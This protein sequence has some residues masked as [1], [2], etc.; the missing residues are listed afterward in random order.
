[1]S[2]PLEPATTASSSGSSVAHRRWHRRSRSVPSRRQRRL[3]MESL[4]DRRLLAGDLYISEFMASNSDSLDD[5][6]G[7]SS[8][9]IEVFN[10]GSTTVDLDGYFLTDD[11]SDLTK[12]EFPSYSL[13]AGQSLVVF[14][15]SRDVTLPSGEMHTN[16]K[17]ASGGE[18]LGLVG[19]DGSTVLHDFGASYPVQFEDVSYGIGMELTSST[20]TLVS[21]GDLISAWEP[22]SDVLGLSWTEASFDDS[23]WP[24]SGPSPVG[25][26]SSPGDYASIIQTPLSNNA[27]SL[28]VRYEF[29][30][31]SLHDVAALDLG[32]RFD[33]GYVAYVNGTRIASQNAPD[34]ISWNSIAAALHPDD[35]A[36]HLETVGANQ[37]VRSLR[38]GQNVL[39]IHG[40]NVSTTSSD[41]LFDAQL[42]GKSAT[43]TQ[44]EE[45]GFRQ[46]PTP[47]WVN[48]SR[49]AGYNDSVSFS[50][51]HGFYTSS[52]TLALST[53][54]A[55]DFIVYT[56]DGSEP[57]V[58]SNFNITNGQLYTNPLTIHQSG[59]VRAAAFENGFRSVPSITQ[60]YIFLDDVL[61]QS[62]TGQS[63]AGWPNSSVN[64]QLLDYGMDPDI[65]SQYGSQA[66]KD[67]LTEISSFSISTDV[68]HLFDSQTGIYVNAQNGGRSWERPASVELLENDG[69]SGFQVNA[70][71]RIRGG[72]SRSGDNPKHAFRFYFRDEYGPTKLN[73]PLF[74]DEGTDQFD[75]LD[76]R[77]AQNYSWSFNGDPQNTFVREV[78]SRDLQR[79]LGH[80]STL[81][82]YHH[83]YINGVYWGLFQTQERVND[84]Y[85]ETYF[86]GD[87]DDYDVVKAGLRT[88]GGPTEI[89][90]GNDQAWL[91]LFQLGQDLADNPTV[92]AN[93]FFTM[94]GLRP[95]GTRDTSLPV[96]VDMENLIDYNLI[97]F[98]TGNL[99]SGLSAFIGNEVGNNWFGLRNRLNQDQGFVFFAHDAE[100]SLGVGNTEFVDRTGPFNEGFQDF[101]AYSNPQFLHQDLLASP[102]YR[103]AFADRV[104]KHMF[105]N[106]AMTPDQ[107]AD[108][109]NERIDVVEDV[110]IAE[111]ARWGD[112][113]R[114]V[115]LNK[116]D[117]RLEVNTI[118][119]Y[120]NS[121]GQTVLGQLAGDGLY[122]SLD[123]PV[124]NQHGGSVP[125][126]F[127]A[128]L[129]ATTG[130]IFY[131]TDGSDP[132]V[133]GGAVSSSASVFNGTPITITSDTVVKARTF[134][135]GVWSALTEAQFTLVADPAASSN[136]RV[137]EMNFNPGDPT[138]AELAVNAVLDN[139][140]FE[141]VEFQNVGNTPIDVGGVVINYGTPFTLPAATL[142]PGAIGLVVSNLSA[143]ELR[144]GS[145][146]HIL[147]E[148]AA[149]RLSNS[150][151]TV[152]ITAS[153][154]SSIQSFTYD[155][156]NDWP[157]FADGHGETMRVI[158]AFGDNSDPL[159]WLPSRHAGGTP[160]E[161]EPVIASASPLRV[162]EVMYHPAIGTGSEFVELY[163]SGSTTLLLQGYEFVEGIE[164]DFD[165]SFQPVLDPGER[166]VIVADIAEF[167][168][169]YGNQVP[170]IG[171]FASGSLSNGGERLILVDNDRHLLHDFAYDDEGLWPTSPDG[172]GF[173]LEIIDI[174]GDYSSPTNWQPST[175]IGGT[176]GTG[177]ALSGDFNGDMMWNCSDINQLTTE[178]A[179]GT[180]SPQFDLTGDGLVTRAD[181]T[182][183]L[184]T[185]GA[186]NPAATGGFPFLEAD[187][188]LDGVVDVGDYVIWNGSRFSVTSNWCDGNFDGNNVVDV[189]DLSIWNVNKFAS[190]S[191]M[192]LASRD[193]RVPAV[194]QTD[195]LSRENI[196][197]VQSDWTADQSFTVETSVSHSPAT[198]PIDV[199]TPPIDVAAPPIRHRTVTRVTG[200][201][202]RLKPESMPLIDSIFAN[203]WGE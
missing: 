143:F 144:Y 64:D 75:V 4:E 140:D 127:A 91:D 182:A 104:H 148:N 170:V 39:A 145:Q 17:L 108:R 65:I 40:M 159:N 199:A 60:S 161:A 8:D 138:A 28:Y 194:P 136:F 32:V 107:N 59:V 84:A 168:S 117:W 15:S 100:H 134:N 24:V 124:L 37:G 51:P 93:N 181:T 149:N 2:K 22:T 180:H 121:R 184:S 171:I 83:L 146:H 186:M 94:Q 173:S 130:T 137:T 187:A 183:W 95:D 118:L 89:A 85:G 99:D 68:D 79:D 176:P 19:P 74:G 34:T 23:S 9:W 58:D 3:H 70:G 141:F 63:P 44:P 56:L 120:F 12:W 43:V 73:Y 200:G 111:A 36:I 46:S 50:L 152:V 30:L 202:D 62:P 71:L 113:K 123:A 13:A 125:S 31:S 179:A 66:I 53:P 77:T 98:Y 18:Y 115:P 61:Q 5:G 174:N 122:P 26:E 128:T 82:R 203:E 191:P 193:L 165:L 110:I 172:G 157:S 166:A 116:T 33:D 177:N 196:H 139:D 197:P 80:Q 101:G 154:S 158:D 167:T 105:N 129:A 16:F 78:F 55:S 47:G 133:T 76:L 142:Q 35:E 198:P 48:E 29:S 169:V 175:T 190:S 20:R 102:E 112:A 109:L 97:L 57:T 38:V 7:E 192:G 42:T 126:G 90:D 164:F 195:S 72:F 160:G 92:N 135:F 178:V 188:N 114:S 162:T 189:M 150:G 49:F 151:E 45:T 153:D 27:Q 147:G 69:S 54:A 106:G 6:F 131:T 86:G 52:Q 185:G 81:S 156:D 155:D 11:A 96:L 103:L 1:M 14:A 132:R 10:D 67:A 25:Y 163:N 87:K 41:L 88:T 119:P 21:S 201:S